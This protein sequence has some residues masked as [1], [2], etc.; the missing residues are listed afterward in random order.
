MLTEVISEPAA[1]N[2]SCMPH[3]QS[4][5]DDDF[6]AYI[7]KDSP[8]SMAIG[9]GQPIGLS[10]ARRLGWGI[11]LSWRWGGRRGRCGLGLGTRRGRRCSGL[12]AGLAGHEALGIGER[13]CRLR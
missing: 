5:S 1:S 12:P 8:L 4:L 10:R 9:D 3:I 7:E 6:S 13:R 2:A 11:A